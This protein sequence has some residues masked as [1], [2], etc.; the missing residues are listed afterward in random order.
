[1]GFSTN[2]IFIIKLEISYSIKQDATR[3][4]YRVG[5]IFKHFYYAS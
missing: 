3:K 2:V 5:I 1:M 4:V